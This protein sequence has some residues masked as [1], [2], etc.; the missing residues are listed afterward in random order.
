MNKIKKTFYILTGGPGV[1]KTTLLNE[2]NQQ[3]YQT[4][5][6][7]AREIIR[8]ET[9]ARTDALP[10]KN[11]THYAQRM[12]QASL[13][14]YDQL[15]TAHNQG[16]VFFDRGILDAVCYMK[17]EKIPLPNHLMQ[18]IRQSTYH[19]TAFVLPPWKEIYTTDDERKQSWEEAVYTF[20]KIK[21]TYLDFGYCLVE[22]PKASIAERLKFIIE[23]VHER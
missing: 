5:P 11:K 15:R 3:G 19:T 4:V 12:L 14:T 13:T 17:M 7:E 6:E 10:W 2:L 8:A 21:E 22:V 23:K 18:R 1:G 9:A 16:A 20:E